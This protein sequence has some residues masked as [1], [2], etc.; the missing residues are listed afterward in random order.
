MNDITTTTIKDTVS[1]I[2]NGTSQIE[3]FDVNFNQ[4]S[5]TVNYEG[6]S[7]RNVEK[8][9]SFVKFIK[10][11]LGNFEL[12]NEKEIIN[13][14]IKNMGLI[15]LIEKATSIIKKHFPNNSFVLE[16]DK[17]PEIPSFNKLLI[18]IKGNDETFEKDW[19][20]IK[21][22]NKEIRVLSLY[23]ESVKNLLSIDLW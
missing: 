1:I 13:F 9:P 4:V 6:Y 19:E 5:K 12:L 11:T 15:E 8:Y 21:L 22:V 7:V 17:D 3:E 2:E 23:D 20:E 18:Y 14:I 10:N 16:F